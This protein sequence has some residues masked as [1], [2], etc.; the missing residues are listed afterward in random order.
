MTVVHGGMDEAEVRALGIDPG[1]VLD[2][3][4]NLH[5]AGPSAAVM[6][7]VR[8]ARLDRYPPAD[9]GPLRDAIA[10]HEEVQP[11]WV[12]PTAGATAAIHLLARALV[13]PGQ[14]AVVFGPTF[15]EYSSAIHAAGGT[16]EA[17]DAIPPAFTPLV[18]APAPLGFLANPNNPTGY[19]LS[20][21]AV[22][23]ITRELG[24]L[25]VVD[26]AYAAFV[27]DGWDAV[28]LVRDGEDVAVV[29]SMTKLHAIP[30]IRLGYVVARPALIERLTALQPSWSVDAVAHAAGPVALAEHAGRIAMLD[31]MWETREEMRL[32]LVGA[33]FRIGPSAANFLLIE[34]GDGRAARMRLLRAGILVRDCASFGLPAWIRVAVPA[35]EEA[36]RV[37]T[38]LLGLRAPEVAP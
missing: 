29:R 11:E 12:L 3:S 2:L 32:A 4:A 22:V 5:P 15:G 21:E 23:A 13:A 7:A 31:A 14:R 1:A 16:V 18:A 33:G 20:R 38:A 37:T 8:G 27:R 34:T 10:A 6:S 30:G 36:A 17:L 19:S 26:A 9:A 24:G 25:L 35:R 28:D